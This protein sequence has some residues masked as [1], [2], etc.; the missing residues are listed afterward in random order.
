MSKYI[1][2]FDHGT[3]SIRACVMNRDGVIMARSQQP[4]A[5]QLAGNI[6]GFAATV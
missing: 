5:Q 4:F 3:T 6:I 2:V 1:M